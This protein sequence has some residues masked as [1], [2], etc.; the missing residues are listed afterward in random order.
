[1]SR[2]IEE[3]TTLRIVEYLRGTVVERVEDLFEDVARDLDL[4]HI[5]Y[6]RYYHYSDS[7]ISDSISTYPVGWQLRYSASNYIS[8]DPVV[9]F[10][11][12]AVVPFDWLQLRNG[13]PKVEAFFAD[14]FTHDVGRNG[15]SLPLRNRDGEASLVSFTSDHTDNVWSEYTT[16]NMRSLQLTAN[17]INVVACYSKSNVYFP[18][19]LTERE[20]RSLVLLCREG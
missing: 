20:R 8:I 18:P 6:L 19:S 1:M 15:I 11:C 3:T 13:D 5:S 17:L 7:R 16:N 10:G 2:V 14:F 9:S 12:E 4:K